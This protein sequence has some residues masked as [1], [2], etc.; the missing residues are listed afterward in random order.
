MQSAMLVFPSFRSFIM[1]PRQKRLV[2]GELVYFVQQRN[3]FQVRFDLWIK[4]KSLPAEVWKRNSPI[5]TQLSRSILFIV[6]ACRCIWTVEGV[7]GRKA[8]MLSWFS[9]PYGMWWTRRS[10]DPFWYSFQDMKISWPSKIRFIFD[11]SFIHAFIHLFILLFYSVTKNNHWSS[12]EKLW[13]IT[14]SE[15]QTCRESFF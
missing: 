9:R 11:H 14:N 7:Y 3:V 5:D 15:S 2:M 8:W 4:K 13:S 12:W 10:K 6:I 1:R